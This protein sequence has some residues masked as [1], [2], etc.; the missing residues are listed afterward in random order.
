MPKS[1]LRREIFARLRALPP[2]ERS[3]RSGA[4]AAH[5]EGSEAFAAARTIFSFVALP[6]EPDLAPLLLSHP[7]KRWAFPR[8]EAGERL[9]FHEMNRLEES[10][11]GSLGISEPDPRRHPPVSPAGVDLVL[12]P[13]VA[14]DPATRARLGRGKG[15]YDRFLARVLAEAPSPVLVGIAFAEQLAPVPAEAHDIPM[16]RLLTELGWV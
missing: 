16:Q 7:E 15:H 13:G 3:A 11:A 12:V 1:S 5:L 14:F 10:L 6:S 2:R 8:I 4:I 9:V